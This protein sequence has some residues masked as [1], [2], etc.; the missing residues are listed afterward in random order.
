MGDQRSKED[1]VRMIST[2]MYVTNFPDHTNAKELWSICSQYRNVIDSFIPN[3]KSKIGSHLSR[4]NAKVHAPFEAPLFKG[5]HFPVSDSFNIDERVAW[6]DIEGVPLRGKIYWIRVKEVSG[7]APVFLDSHEDSSESDNESIEDKSNEGLFEKNS[8]VDEIPETI[9][10]DVKPGEIKSSV[11]KDKGELR[12]PLGFTPCNIENIKLQG[13][14]N[15]DHVYSEKELS[16]KVCSKEDVGWKGKVIVM[17]DFNEVRTA[18]EKFGSLFNASGAAS[19][20]SFIPTGGLVEVP[21]GGYSYTWVHRSA[22]KMSKLDRFLIPED[23]MN[24]SWK[25]YNIQRLNA[26]LKFVKKLKLLKGQIL[27]WVKDKKDKAYI[28]KKN[29]KK[30]IVDIDSLLDKEIGLI[31]YTILKEEIEG[32]VWDCGLNKSLGPDGF[33][34]G[35]YQKFW[36]LLE[37]DVVAAVNQFFHHGYVQKG[38]NASF[39]A[40]I[41]KSHGAKMVK[42]F[43][44]IS[45]IGSLYK[46]IAK[47]LANRLVTVMGNLVNEVQYAFI[48]NRKILDGPFILNELIHWCKARKKQSMIFKVDF[49][50]AFD[51]VRWDFLDDILKNFGFGSHDVVFIGQWSESNL[52]TIIH[53]LECFFRASGLRINLQKSKL[54]GL[55]VESSVVEVASND[56]GCLAIKPPFPYMGIIIGGHMSRIKAWDDAINK[57]LCR[58]SK[59]K[60]KS[61]SIGGRLTLLKSSFFNGVDPSVRKMTFVKWDNVLAS[62]EKGGLG[63][64]SFSGLN[65]AFIVKRTSRGGTEQVQMEGLNTYLDGTVMSSM[66]DRRRWTL[67]GDGEFSVS[68]ARRFINDK[69]LETVG[70]KTRWNKFVPNNVNILAWRIKQDFLP[71]CLNISRRAV[72]KNIARWW[73]VN[74]TSSYEECVHVLTCLMGLQHCSSSSVS[75]GSKTVFGIFYSSN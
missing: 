29:L 22:S 33:T 71:T 40:L 74:M 60:M 38:G 14:D 72:Y 24:N 70:S 56:I 37:E 2:S 53:V 51:L 12:Y 69:I 41:L 42:D 61:L 34:F 13:P 35:F 28:L 55:A 3:R 32:A 20:N 25:S 8:E 62:K 19:F 43:R 66:L 9:F 46:I 5:S 67:S 52:S 65:H 75:T 16:P 26:I 49:E 6:I 45:L 10:E 58:L 44:P 23:L 36:F 39:I 7:W 11:K 48:A 57:V 31:L 59:C 27:L 17:G 47:L 30:K 64:S 50:K 1:N 73:D 4:C 68:S 15:Q 21:S 63:V 18:E 54:I